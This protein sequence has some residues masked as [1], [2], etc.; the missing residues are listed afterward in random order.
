MA[1]RPELYHQEQ[2]KHPFPGRRPHPPGFIP[3]NI[4]CTGLRGTWLNIV[5]PDRAPAFW[6]QKAGPSANGRTWCPDVSH[7]FRLVTLPRSGR[8]GR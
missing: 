7:W 8:A 3:G 5:R 2:A 1:G 4:L 6:R